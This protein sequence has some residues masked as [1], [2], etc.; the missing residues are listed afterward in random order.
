VGQVEVV[1]L[2]KDFLE[3]P[4]VAKAQQIKVLRVVV[5]HNKLM[6]M[7]VLLA[8]VGRAAQPQ[9]LLKGL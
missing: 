3:L 5:L 7:E 9:T 4:Q 6:P 1:V 8:E 2:Y